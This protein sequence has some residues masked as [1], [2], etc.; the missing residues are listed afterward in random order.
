LL[1]SL[2]FVSS[3]VTFSSCKSGEKLSAYAITAEYDPESGTLTGEE[4][5]TYVNTT[6]TEISV[7][8][9][10]LYPNAYREDAAYEPVSAVYRSVAYYDGESYGNISV[11]GVAGAER[12]EIGGEDENILFVYLENSVFPDETAEVTID[13]TVTLAKVDHR[14]GI[15][16]KVVNLC[17]F[18]PVLCVWEE[19]KGYYECLYYSDGDPFYSECASY[20]VKLTVP[21]GYTV[22]AS[23]AGE[24]RETGGK[25]GEKTT[26]TYTMPESRDFALCIG[27]DVKVLEKTA[28][29]TLVRY[30]YYDDEGANDTLQ[31]ACK[32]ID[33]FSEKFGEYAYDSYTMVQTGFCYGGMEYP[34]MVL[35][36][37]GLTGE[38]LAYTAVHETAHQWWYAM[39][40]NN[41]CEYAWMDEGLAEYSTVLFYEQDPDRG[42]TRKELVDT[43][44]TRYRAY[45][46]VYGQIFGE[47]DTSMSRNLGKFVSEYEYVNLI[48]NKGVMLFDALR[49][50]VGDARFF[51]GLQDYFRTYCH[52]I[53]LPEEMIACFRRTGVDVEGLFNGFVS[54]NDEI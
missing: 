32:A 22:V 48:Y 44:L 30:M 2:L 23:A 35:L 31:T 5:F 1:L 27:K 16:E 21:T 9:F 43:A 14:T 26:Y 28:G 25:T 54:G 39:V 33:Y 41:Q 12:F 15:T 38:D 7:L 3:L 42:R 29:D 10:N 20:S 53:A 13:F 4:V 6:D 34:G 18:Y 50:G 11:G 47:I 45:Y 17:N 49:S 52:K 24:G 37:D 36:S 51:G 19:G 40:G 8:E 46:G